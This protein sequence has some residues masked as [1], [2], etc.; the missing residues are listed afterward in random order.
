[1]WAIYRVLFQI[2]K[3]GKNSYHHAVK[4]EEKLTARSHVFQLLAIGLGLHVEAHWRSQL[5]ENTATVV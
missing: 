4:R 5:V 3:G 2:N 1:V